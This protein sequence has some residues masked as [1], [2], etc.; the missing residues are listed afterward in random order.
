MTETVGCLSGLTRT[1]GGLTATFCF[2]EEFIGFQ[3][4]FPARKVLPGVCQI[5]CVLAVIEQGERVTAALREILLA[6]YAAPVFPGEALTCTVQRAADAG[7]EAVFKA[8]LTTHG[9]KVTELKLR[10]TLA[11]DRD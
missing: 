10:V 6:K 7:G 4:H 2:P 8:K 3:G 9:K 11:P 1:D 5:H